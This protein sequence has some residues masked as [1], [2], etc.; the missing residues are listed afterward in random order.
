MVG[1][2]VGHEHDNRVRDGN[3]SIFGT[4]VDHGGPPNPGGAPAP[5]DGQGSTGV[6]LSRLAA[7][8]RELSFNDPDANNGE[9]GRPDRRGGRD[10]RNVELLVRD[11]YA[12]P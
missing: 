4:I 10:D 3:L 2:V 6:S 7:I 12:A 8:S 1:Y 9:D 5:A 11:P